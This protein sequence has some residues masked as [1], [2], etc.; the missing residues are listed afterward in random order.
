MLFLSFQSLGDNDRSN[1]L[2]FRLEGKT[3]YTFIPAHSYTFSESCVFDYHSGDYVI[4]QDSFWRQHFITHAAKVYD[5]VNLLAYQKVGFGWDQQSRKRQMVY[6]SS[7]GIKLRL[8]S[9]SNIIISRIIDT[10]NYNPFMQDLAE[11]DFNWIQDYPLSQLFKITNGMCSDYFYTI[12]S[13]VASIDKTILRD[14]ILD[15][16][17]RLQDYYNTGTVLPENFYQTLL[18][19]HILVLSFC[20]C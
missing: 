7:E 3:Y 1:L 14:D 4:E 10:D 19:R 15:Y 9:F 6:L 11:S 20:D 16:H 17:S 8:D 2:Q 13:N 18:Q 5:K 12:S